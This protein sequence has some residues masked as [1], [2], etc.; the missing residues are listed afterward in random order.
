M[1]RWESDTCLSCVWDMEQQGEDWVGTQV[2]PC[3]KHE[4]LEEAL[5]IN[6][7]KNNTIT[8]ICDALDLDP[9]EITNAT[10]NKNITFTIL[11]SGDLLFHIKN[12]S[13]EE[14]SII[15]GLTIDSQYSLNFDIT[16]T[17]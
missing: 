1:I 7:F 10:G 3:T 16:T 5:N 15:N 8:A 9:A 12:F 14:I 17:A 13:P 11:D 2:T 4:T 6:R